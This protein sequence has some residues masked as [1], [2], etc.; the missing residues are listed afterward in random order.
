METAHNAMA[1]E[2]TY[3]TLRL[4]SGER[5]VRVDAGRGGLASPCRLTRGDR[6]STF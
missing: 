6:L 1:D 5:E 3:D 2:Q 4:P